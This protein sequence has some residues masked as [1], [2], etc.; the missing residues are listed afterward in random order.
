[1]ELGNGKK[2]IKGRSL[3]TLCKEREKEYTKKKEEEKVNG[4]KKIAAKC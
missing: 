4:E 1:M 2:Y 3:E